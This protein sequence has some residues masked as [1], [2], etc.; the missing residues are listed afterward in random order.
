MAEIV[1][2]P[3]MTPVLDSPT[4]THEVP[5]TSP[6]WRTL[7]V[8]ACLWVLAWP[9]AARAEL[10]TF[11]FEGKVT[12]VPMGFDG[13]FKVG[14]TIAGSYTFE[15]ATVD[16]MAGDPSVGSY[17]AIKSFMVKVGDYKVAANAGKINVFDDFSGFDIYSAGGTAPTGDA[18]NGFKLATASLTLSDSTK[19]AFAS[20][21][22]PAAPPD[23]AKFDS[24]EFRLGFTKL[25]PIGGFQ[26]RSVLGS[27]TKLRLGVAPEPSALASALLGAAGLALYGCR[28]RSCTG[29][30]GESSGIPA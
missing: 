7:L 17:D 1:R 3:E 10:V 23:L 2:D 25:D 11:L 12:Q 4:R 20:D 29:R 9:A 13:T 19:A 14:D 15:S 8:P 18:V 30:G 27:I 24:T 21:A 28:Q 22:L 26:T 5:R 16:G 6:S